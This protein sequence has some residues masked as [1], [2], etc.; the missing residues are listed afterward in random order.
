VFRLAGGERA[1]QNQHFRLFPVA[2]TLKM[3]DIGNF[4][5]FDAVYKKKSN[6]SEM[7]RVAEILQE[8]RNV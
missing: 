7:V 3:T 6:I 5:N 4:Q 8:I 1:I 2:E